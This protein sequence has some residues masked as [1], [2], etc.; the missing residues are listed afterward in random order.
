MDGWGTAGQINQ[1]MRLC[2]VAVFEMATGAVR[3]SKAS[4][5]LVVGSEESLYGDVRTRCKQPAACA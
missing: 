1:C 3:E 2:T 5:G 4:V